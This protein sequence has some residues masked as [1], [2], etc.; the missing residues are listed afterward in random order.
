VVEKKKSGKAINLRKFTATAEEV[1]DKGSLFAKCP[2][3]VR[4]LKEDLQDS[5][6]ER[7]LIEGRN[8]RWEETPDH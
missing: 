4:K 1:Q 5:V 3:D 7:K 2:W 6:K 8:V